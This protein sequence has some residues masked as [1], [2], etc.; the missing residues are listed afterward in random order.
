M[1]DASSA[2]SSPAEAPLRPGWF[3]SLSEWAPAISCAFGHVALLAWHVDSHDIVVRWCQYERDYWHYLDAGG[4]LEVL[5]RGK[6]AMVRAQQTCLHFQ[7][8]FDLF[9]RDGLDDVAVG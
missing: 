5:C 6:A 7:E 9:V 1:M 4:R 2:R 8:T 3:G